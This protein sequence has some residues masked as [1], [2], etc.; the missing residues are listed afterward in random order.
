MAPWCRTHS[1][2]GAEFLIFPEYFSI[3]LTSLFGR[4]VCACLDHQLDAIQAVHEPFVGLFTSLAQQHG[5]HILAGTFP[6][7]QDNGQYHNRAWLFR[8]DGSRDYQD[9]LQMTRFESER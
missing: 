2:K 8:L 1:Y 9:K 3:E 5:L 6:L 4:E 7:R